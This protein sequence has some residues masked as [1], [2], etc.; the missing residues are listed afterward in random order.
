MDQITNDLMNA[1]NAWPERFYIILNGVVKYKGGNGPF[2][3]IPDEV[4]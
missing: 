2:G 4:E 1:Y 3:Y